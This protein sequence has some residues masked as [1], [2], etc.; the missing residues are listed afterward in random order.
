[1]SRAARTARA[2]PDLR[3][4]GFVKTVA[5][6]RERVPSF[7]K[8]PFSIPAVRGLKSIM[9]NEGATFL[10]GENGCGKSTLIEAIAICAGFN[11]EGGSKN[12]NFATR[13]SESA[14]SEYLQVARGVRRERDG[15]FLR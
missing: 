6:V 13:R 8:Y 12:F 15:F 14:L 11:L 3:S 4:G 5:L 9:L 1:M 2:G 10:V 7:E